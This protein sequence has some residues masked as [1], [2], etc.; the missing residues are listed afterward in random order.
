MNALLARPLSIPKE[1]KERKRGFFSFV[2]IREISEAKYCVRTIVPM[3]HCGCS[4]VSMPPY[5]EVLARK[6]S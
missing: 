5:G 1:A 4:L 3:Q 6:M 2:S